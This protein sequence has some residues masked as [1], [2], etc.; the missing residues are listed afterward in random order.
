MLQYCQ[1]LKMPNWFVG[2]GW[3]FFGGNT[4]IQMFT[5]TGTKRVIT[6]DS[7]WVF[8]RNVFSYMETVPRQIDKEHFTTYCK[9]AAPNPVPGAD[10][11][12]VWSCNAALQH[13][14]HSRLL[15]T[16][17]VQSAKCSSI[18]P[19]MCSY[20]IVLQPKHSWICRLSETGQTKV[21][22]EINFMMKG[23]ITI[24]ASVALCVATCWNVL[25]CFNANVATQNIQDKNNSSIWIEYPTDTHVVLKHVISAKFQIHGNPGS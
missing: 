25:K 13:A 24:P 23:T 18:Q 1:Y 11:S 4:K 15:R 7:W 9:R 12:P 17:L 21:N 5:E 3:W 22:S 20:R 6:H 16:S 8:Y 14:A 19:K 10:N 2:G